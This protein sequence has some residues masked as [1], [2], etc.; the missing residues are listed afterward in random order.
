LVFAVAEPVGVDVDV[1]SPTSMGPPGKNS[2]VV[3]VAPRAVDVVAPGAVVADARVVA[4][5][6]VVVVAGA[7]W[8]RIVPTMP[9]C[10]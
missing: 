2:V 5:A 3:V 4:V 9:C 8:T 6:R 10:W 1:V 7:G